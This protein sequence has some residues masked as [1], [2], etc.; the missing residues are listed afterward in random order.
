MTYRL[1]G[2]TS[3]LLTYP[4]L[5]TAFTQTPNFTSG[6]SKA[7]FDHYTSLLPLLEGMADVAVAVA[8]E[9]ESV[10][11]PP[12]PATLQDLVLAGRARL[13]RERAR[14]ERDDRRAALE[15]IRTLRELVRP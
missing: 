2:A 13:N 9:A 6:G 5:A 3:T 8:A 1:F 4:D 15:H 11:L 7:A 12:A 14:S 10:P